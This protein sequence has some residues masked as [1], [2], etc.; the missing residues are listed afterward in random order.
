MVARWTWSLDHAPYLELR[1]LLVATVLGSISGGLLLLRETDPAEARR[2]GPFAPVAFRGVL[3]LSM[4]LTLVDA[5]I[6]VV[7]AVG[8]LDVR[9]LVVAFVL[10]LIAEGLFR[11]KVWALFLT[12]VANPLVVA[13][14]TLVG[15]SLMRS[16][17]PLRTDPDVMLGQVLTHGTLLLI[18]T[19]LVQLVLPIPVV[20]AMIR[21]RVVARPRLARALRALVPIV[22]WGA[23]GSAIAGAGYLVVRGPTSVLDDPC[24]GFDAPAENRPDQ[25]PWCFLRSVWTDREAGGVCKHVCVGQEG[26]RE[27]VLLEDPSAPAPVP[28]PCPD[29]IPTNGCRFVVH[30]HNGA[31]CLCVEMCGD[32]PNS[33]R[34]VGMPGWLGGL[35]STSVVAR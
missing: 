21:G 2:D 34:S 31:S 23:V 32:D 22:L 4:V 28:S 17:M 25:S 8:M 1:A 14:M 29:T 5:T 10:V 16:R 33:W 7:M 27:E 20:E 24:R 13:G 11:L 18:V 26:M 3:T 15:M 30:C 6:L 19:T 35:A 9:P 12:W